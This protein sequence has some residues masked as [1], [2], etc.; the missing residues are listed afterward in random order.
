MG[1]CHC[2]AAG[3][4]LHT[5]PITSHF[6]CFL[7]VTSTILAVALVVV[8]REG[9]FAQVLGT[10]G[11]FN[12]T[13]LRDWQ[14][15]SPPQPLFVST[16]RSYEALFLVLEPWPVWSAWDWTHLL[17]RYP[18]RFVSTTCECGTTCPTSCHICHHLDAALLP[19]CHV[20]SS[21]TPYLCPSY[22][23]GLIWLL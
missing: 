21:L 10:Y 4:L 14:F 17:H 16:A 23:S 20:L 9:G 18:F 12:R 13:L 1:K 2:L 11:T 3:G 22:T 8:P 6:T 5:H 15:I 19:P 7:Y